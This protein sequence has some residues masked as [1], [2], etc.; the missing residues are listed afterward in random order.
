MAGY[1]AFA[2]FYDELTSNIDYEKR[3][4]YFDVLIDKFGGK[5]GGI[6]LDLCCGTGSLSEEFY[7]LGYDVIATD[8]SMQMLNAALD[9]KFDSGSTVQYLC[10]DMRKLDMFGTIDVTICALDSL[11]HLPCVDDLESVFKRVHL[12][13]EPGGLFIF[14]VN[15]VFK[16]KCILADNVF[17]YDMENVFCVW[18]NTYNDSEKR[19]DI[20]LN[21]FARDNDVYTRYNEN[22]SEYAYELDA[23]CSLLFK[24]GFEI[25]AMY[26]YDSFNPV[27][28]NSEKVV[29]CCKKPLESKC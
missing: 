18:E 6:L 27:N 21:I 3:A 16:H 29:F 25:C 22:F 13:C 12:F 11:N 7:K 10:Q 17:T 1:N 2:L 20:V 14:D 15:T 28:E 4:S 24:A 5:K 26:D 23:I 9:K 19:T 8:A